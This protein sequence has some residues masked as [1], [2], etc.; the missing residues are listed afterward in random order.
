LDPVTRP[1]RDRVDA[2]RRLA[3]ALSGMRDDDVVVLGLVRGGVVVAALV[4]GQLE[5][6]LD[7]VVVRKLGVPFQPELA[8]G[9]VAEDGVRIVDDDVI[10]R[11][12]VTSAELAAIEEQQRSEV[13]RRVAR[14]RH[15]RPHVPLVGRTALV[16]D[17]GIATGSTARVAC[18]VA[19]AW[20]ARRVVLAVPVAPPGWEDGFSGDADECVALSTPA[21]FRAVGQFYDEF[22]QVGDEEVIRCLEGQPPGRPADGRRTQ[23]D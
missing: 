14:Y 6:P 2:G 21:S 23:A 3:T 7:V 13:V 10:R 22:D 11:A 20:G 16:V 1:F 12:G 8:M 4:A 5:A 18:R 17:D 15:G 9:A 19:R